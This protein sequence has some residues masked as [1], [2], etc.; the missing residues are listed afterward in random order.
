MTALLQELIP[1]LESQFRLVAKP[2]ARL[3][4]GVSSGGWSAIWLQ[5]NAPE[6][7]GGCWAIAPDPVDFSAFQM[8]DLYSEINMFSNEQG[9][10]TPSYRKWVAL[11]TMKTAM[12][13]QQECG[14]ETAIDPTGR[15]GQQ[16]DAW[17]AA[18]SSKD[19]ETGLPRRMFDR[20]TGVI[21]KS[22]VR[23]WGNYDISQQ[24]LLKWNQL[25]PVMMDRVRLYCGEM[26]SYYLN[27]AVE[28]LQ[29]VIV[30]QKQRYPEITA[31]TGAGLVEIVPGADH[32]SI[33]HKT[34]DLIV[35][36]MRDHLVAHGLHDAVAAGHPAQNTGA[37]AAPASQPGGQP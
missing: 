5:L 30:E 26:D 7:F 35:K 4:R 20:A 25:G 16:W 29:Q 17:D 18:F 32:G 23:R 21:D 15:S 37:V 10:P 12:T 9:E 1:L 8:T 33:V 24:L 3:L 22:V 2:E 36:Q 6:V 13:V 14:M 34:H 31:T 19:R 28:R 11:S 27:R